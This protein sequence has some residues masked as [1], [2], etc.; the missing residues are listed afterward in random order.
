MRDKISSIVS[1]LQFVTLEE[2]KIVLED[3]RKKTIENNL[4]NMGSN[5]E[6]IKLLP[7]ENESGEGGFITGPNSEL[8]ENL[9]IRKILIEKGLNEKKDSIKWDKLF[10]RLFRELKKSIENLIEDINELY[11]DPKN[12]EI[13]YFDHSIRYHELY[14][15]FQGKIDTD[16]LKTIEELLI[17]CR[18]LLE[19]LEYRETP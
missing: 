7:E 9:E 8:S 12:L 5:G 11:K 16:M 2:I 10:E 6:I 14:R 13:E 1:E 15:F 18:S 3:S 19:K 17:K 4:K